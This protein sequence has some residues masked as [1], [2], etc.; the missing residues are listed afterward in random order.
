MKTRLFVVA[1]LI[2]VISAAAAAERPVQVPF[3]N[4]QST[5]PLTDLEQFQ[6]TYGATLLKGFTSCPACA[7]RAAASR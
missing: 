7:A 5:K 6:D 3:I 2:L 1:A 4:D